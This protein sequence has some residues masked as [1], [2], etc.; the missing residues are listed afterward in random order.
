VSLPARNVSI[1]TPNRKRSINGDELSGSRSARL[2]HIV[3]IYGLVSKKL[4]S[5]SRNWLTR[6][7][8]VY[9]ERR[10]WKY[11]SDVYVIGYG[12]EAMCENG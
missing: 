3:C 7:K 12:E 1:F 11:I 10:T 6:A 2:S 5:R 8:I 9:S 4:H